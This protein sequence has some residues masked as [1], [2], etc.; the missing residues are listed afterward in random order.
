MANNIRITAKALPRIHH[1][2]PLMPR[3][4]PDVIAQGLR[5]VK[6]P[7]VAA[8]G[9]SPVGLFALRRELSARLRSSGGRPALEGTTRRAKVPLSDEDWVKIA[10]IAD[11]VTRGGIKVTAGQVASEILHLAV[12]QSAGASLHG[13]R[14]A[15]HRIARELAGTKTVPDYLGR[16]KP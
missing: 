13:L 15:H 14:R 8:A 3:V 7:G 16:K 10:R 5:A 12:A 11:E 4:E 9:G 6:V 1:I 2:G